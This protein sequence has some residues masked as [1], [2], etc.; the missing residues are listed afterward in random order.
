N[1]PVDDSFPDPAA[2]I[3]AGTALL[4]GL[5]EQRRTGAGSS[6]E[7]TMLTSTAYV[8]SND[9][10]MADGT[11]EASIADTEQLGTCALYRLYECADGWLFLAAVTDREWDGVARSLSITDSRFHDRAGRRAHDGLL[12]A[13]IADW[14]AQG[15]TAH[16][17]EA[18]TAN[19]VPATVVELDGI[20]AWLEREGALRP[21]DHPAF[22]PYYR[23]PPKVTVSGADPV[24]APACATGEHTVP[25]L[26][27]LGWSD[28]AVQALLAAGIVAEW[29][30]E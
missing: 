26:R 15:T 5:L 20:E 2:G 18:L 24:T 29:Q 11:T 22:E 8:M 7:T 12:A 6:L 16:R 17:V 3:G 14:C 28:D 9:L 25:L 27:E 13:C 10:V 1:A 30:A 4:L 21:A 23:L 19:A